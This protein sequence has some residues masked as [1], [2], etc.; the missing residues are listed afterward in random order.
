MISSYF[1]GPITEMKFY[2]FL[3]FD[4]DFI[5][6]KFY[7]FNCMGPYPVQY[8]S[9]LK[10]RGMWENPSQ[11]NNRKNAYEIIAKKI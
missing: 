11:I 8:F 3:K 1:Y 6:A 7:R 10:G 2:K 5:L 4:Q 9:I